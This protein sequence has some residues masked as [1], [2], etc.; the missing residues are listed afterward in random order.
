[1]LQ[2]AAVAGR[3]VD[4]QALSAVSGQ[5]VGELV[6]LLREAVA[7]HVL[8]AAEDGSE[9]YAFRHA[10]VQEAIY[11][12]LLP[13]ERVP[14]HAE[15]ARALTARTEARPEG[16]TAQE[17]GQLAHHWYAAHDLGAAL[18]ASVAAG[19]AAEDTDAPSEALQHYERALELWTQ[20]PAAAARSPLDRVALLRRAAEAA[21]L[22]GTLDRA[23]ALVGVALDGVDPAVDPVRAGALLDR[24][25]RY[26]YVAGDAAAAMAAVER[27]LATIPVEP[28]SPERARCAGDDRPAAHARRAAHRG[29]GAVRGGGRRR[30]PGRR[31]GGGVPRARLPDR[32][33]RRP[34][35][36]RRGDRA[37]R[38]GVR[39]RRGG[40]RR[41]R[42]VPGPHQPRHLL[43]R[44]GPVGGRRGAVP[45]GHG[46]RRPVRHQAALRRDGARGRRRV[47]RAPGPLGRGAGAP[48]GGRGAR[49]AA[50]LRDAPAAGP[51]PLPAAPG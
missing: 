45:A 21:F 48:R 35:R 32:R 43:R 26:R 16:P 39:D 28:P 22:A 37:L 40:R 34:G 18:L 4:H 47:P 24:L 29:A 38:A 5:P 11:D 31:P 46:A 19:Q 2:L 1:V 41:R 6:G 25:S 51:R 9:S 7:H 20:A 36:P 23:I 12:D 8:A 13:V 49:P 44:A 27:A 3:R 10:L 42:A 33:V 14:L 50:L 15:Y 17:L 30:P